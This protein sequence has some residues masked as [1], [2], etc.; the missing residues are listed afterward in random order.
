VKSKA[1]S[2]DAFDLLMARRTTTTNTKANGTNSVNTSSGSRELK[3]A[4]STDA[5]SF[6]KPKTVETK[7]HEKPKLAAPSIDTPNGNT[8]APA[9][10]HV[11]VVAV[12][13]RKDIDL[14]SSTTKTKMSTSI[15][16]GTNIT[17]STSFETV[18]GIVGHSDDWQKFASED[19]TTV[20]D[21]LLLTHDVS[22]LTVISPTTHMFL[23]FCGS[24]FRSF[25]HLLI[26]WLFPSFLYDISIATRQIYENGCTQPNIELS[27]IED[28]IVTNIG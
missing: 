16:G 22:I 2:M 9:H 28:N 24:S 25:I 7:L 3:S 26:R 21:F 6:E 27:S 20:A 17:L 15:A 18:L 13:E 14:S 11:P 1:G 19:I 8:S 23:F 5:K 12:A 10:V 4:T